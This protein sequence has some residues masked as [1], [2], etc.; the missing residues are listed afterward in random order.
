[1]RDRG[2]KILLLLPFI[3]GLSCGLCSE[4]SSDEEQIRG[5]I[6]KAV[7]LTEQKDLGELMELVT[8]DFMVMPRKMDRRQTKGMLLYV[9]QRYRDLSILHPRPNV[10]VEPGA[11]TGLASLVFLMLRGG[12]TRPDVEGLTDDLDLWV[13]KVGDY[14][15][16]YRLKLTFVKEDDEWLIQRAH[17]ERFKGTGFSQ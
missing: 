4:E 16:L 2:L 7:E 15:R 10:S 14:T 9:F 12:D 13:R 1:M 6:K 8:G 5:V 17:L 3:L 11:P